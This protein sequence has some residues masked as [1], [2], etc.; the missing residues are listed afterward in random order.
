VEL[1]VLSGVQGAG[2]TTFY[3]A[4]FAETHAHVSRDDFRN[5]RDPARRQRQLVLDAAAAGRGV[6]VDNTSVRRADRAA[7]VALARELGMRAVLYWF[8]PDAK[9]SIA[10]NARREGKAKVPVVAI[11]ATLKRA[12]PPA[13][14]EGFDEAFEVRP[15]EDGGFDVSPLAPAASITPT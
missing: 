6:V 15:R 8:R 4:R 3:R 14:G 12:E 13:A 9:A 5:H 7:L 1:V 2:K 10:R 11:L